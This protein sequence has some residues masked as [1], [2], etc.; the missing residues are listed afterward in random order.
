MEASLQIPVLVYFT[1][2][3]CGPCK[4]FGPLLEKVV[5]DAKGRVK[6]ARV[7]VDASPQLAQQFRIQS[8]P[9]VYIF[10][11]GQPVDAFSGAMPESQ[12]K[13]LLSQFMA[14]TPEEEDAK[15]TLEKAKELLAQGDSEQALQY[16]QA[17]AAQDKENVEALAGLAL[18]HI[19]LGDLEKAEALLRTIPEKAANHE[20]VISANARLAL[21]KSAPK[22][23]DS[24]KLR[25]TLAQTPEDHETRYA[26]ANALFSGGQ[27]EEAIT[28]LLHIVASDK[29]WN[30]GA[31]RKQLLVIFEALGFEHSL[32][33][34]GRR[35]LSAILFK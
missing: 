20:T 16:Y 24:Q 1:A 2:P 11:S 14:A 35:K 23:Q 29:E 17:V 22:L 9:M 13:Q 19:A 34:Q 5:N 31:A 32:S 26:L 10:V 30:E 25:Q 4:Q 3:W 7:D 21:A 8:V 28:E 27:P 6:L 18:A 12:L 33:A 15:A